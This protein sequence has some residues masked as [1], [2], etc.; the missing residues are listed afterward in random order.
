M[1]DVKKGNILLVLTENEADLIVYGLCE[2]TYR[3]K[4]FSDREAMEAIRL[5]DYIIERLNEVEIR[6][7]L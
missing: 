1:I 3:K 7:F 2:L 4:G 5:A 6:E